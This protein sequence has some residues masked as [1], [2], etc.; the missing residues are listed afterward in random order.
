MV[1][2]GSKV[3]LLFFRISQENF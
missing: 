3:H 2:N 1:F